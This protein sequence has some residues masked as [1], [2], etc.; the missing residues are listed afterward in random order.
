MVSLNTTYIYGDDWGM[1]QMIF[2]FTQMMVD[3]VDGGEIL[4]QL[5]VFFPIIL[6]GFQPSFWWCRISQAHP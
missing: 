3:T 6:L 2:C 4:H 5:T 1:V